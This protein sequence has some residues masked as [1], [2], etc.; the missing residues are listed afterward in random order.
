MLFLGILIGIIVWQIVCTLVTVVTDEN[1]NAIISCAMGLIGLVINFIGLLYRS[2]KLLHYRK[3]NVYQ[4]YANG[5]EYRGSFNGWFANYIMTPEMAKNF[6]T[7]DEFGYDYA[8]KFLRSGKEFHSLPQ[9]QEIIESLDNVHGI[10]Q[11][12]LKKFLKN[13]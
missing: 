11:N 8:I 7:V 10:S 4:F 9:K 13:A 1:E 12:F 6:R 3:Y 5:K 2:I